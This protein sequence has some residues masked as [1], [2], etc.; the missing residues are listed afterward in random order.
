MEGSAFPMKVLLVIPPM[1]QINTPYPSTAYLKAYL[2]EKGIECDQKD[3]GIELIDELFSK[4]SLLEIKKQIRIKNDW[5]EFF[6]EAFDDYQNTI[7]PVREYLQGKPSTIEIKLAARDFV[8]E[9]PRFLPLQ[10]EK[11]Q[12]TFQSMNQADRA[13]YIASLYID[14]VADIIK[15]S[16]DDKFEF[17]RYGEKL[18]SSQTSF[19]ALHEQIESSNTYIDQLLKSITEKYVKQYQPDIIA[20]TAPF[21]GNVYGAFK[22]AKFAKDFNP[23]M[24]TVLG[25]GYVNT[26]LRSLQD[27]RIFKYMDYLIFD[28]GERALECLVEYLAG[29][30]TQDQ[31]LRTWFLQN[32]E[33]QKVSSSSERDVD[34]KSIHAP[35]YKGLQLEKYIS[36]I[37]MPNPVHRLW[38]DQ[39][40]NKLILA[41]GCYWKKCT[42]CDITLDYIGRFEPQKA[43]TIV[44]NMQKMI[45]ETGVTGFHFVDEAAPP[46]ILKQISE[47]ILKRKIE[48]T[49]WG[50]IRFDG[51]FTKEVC[52]SMKKAG[53]IAVT[54]GLEV[55]SPRLL[56]LINKGV[57]IEQVAEVTKNF[58]DAGIYVHAYLMYGFPSQT[59]QETVDSLEVVRQLFVNECIDSAFWH[60][61]VATVHSP[62][63][64]TPEKYNIKTFYP[65]IP[66]EGMF[67]INE[68]PFQ[69]S[70]EVDHDMLGEGLKKALYN[71]MHGN[72]LDADVKEWFSVKVPKTTLPKNY[73]QK[74]LKQS[75]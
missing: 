74:I 2:D 24:K 29:K 3:F 38:S 19:S 9:G 39:L 11:L 36:M 20:F 55:A 12:E 43:T 68:I 61:F 15:S 7:D 46:A 4:K 64:K 59:E 33:I 51:I 10:H 27:K 16:I 75:K 60:R 25:G 54:G 44:D 23:K 14:D 65:K 57:T 52:E 41:H 6:L 71:Y 1:T 26:E 18:A 13:K 42:F 70:V 66:R 34:F 72:F 53:C 63:G 17:S 28:D 47:E 58:K 22:I 45:A 50:N 32:N 69:D 48:V 67:A 73:I 30:R 21:P 37:E 40:W 5:I 49:Y 56:K 8:P 31:L 35:T 62:V